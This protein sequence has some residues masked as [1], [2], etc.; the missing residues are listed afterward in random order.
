MPLEVEA[1]LLLAWGRTKRRWHQNRIGLTGT[2][3]QRPTLRG[4]R[5][6]ASVESR[7]LVNRFLILPLSLIYSF[8]KYSAVGIMRATFAPTAKYVIVAIRCTRS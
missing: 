8:L 5:W 1:E 2:S 4:T 3:L 7:G 6:R